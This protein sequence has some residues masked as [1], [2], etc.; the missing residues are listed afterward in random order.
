[1]AESL[2]IKQLER[3]RKAITL[4]D[5]CAPLQGAEEMTEQRG[6]VAYTKG[7][8]IGRARLDGSQEEEVEFTFIWRDR[9]MDRSPEPFLVEGIPN[10]V[11]TALQGR[12]FLREMV[13]DRVTVLVQHLGVESIGFLRRAGGRP[14]EAGACEVTLVYQ[15]TKPDR[16]E[17]GK[18]VAVPASGQDLLEG[19]TEK[20]YGV[21]E[22]ARIPAQFAQDRIDKAQR[23]AN[24]I[25]QGITT[26]VNVVTEALDTQQDA[27]SLGR[28]VVGPAQQIASACRD[29]DEA[30]TVPAVESVQTED[31]VQV[32]AAMVLQAQAERATRQVRHEIALERR[33]L[34]LLEQSE[35]IGTHTALAGEDLRL[36]CLNAYGDA[37]VWQEVA[38]FNGLVGSSLPGG[39]RVYLPRLELS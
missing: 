21:M 8:D 4:R 23:A 37:A 1:M 2:V 17:L 31:P 24:A 16:Y 15:P 32:L 27:A 30:L 13:R 29:F 11:T 34:E 12:E 6:D 36:V 33:R 3:P 19:I 25:H 38:A 39:L 14:R 35:I 9:N 26:A 10:A 5:T 20:W 28:G 22:T 18:F 7:S